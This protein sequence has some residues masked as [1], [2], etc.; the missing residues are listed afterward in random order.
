MFFDCVC[1]SGYLCALQWLPVCAAVVDCVRR[2]SCSCVLQWLF[3]CVAVVARVCC[4]G[5][6]VMEWVV[7]EQG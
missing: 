6:G 2:N 5:C 4:N 3:V 7:C 1:C